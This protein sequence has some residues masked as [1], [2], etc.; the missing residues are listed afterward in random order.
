MSGQNT[1]LFITLLLFATST[2]LLKQNHEF[3]E[4][5]GKKVAPLHTAFLYFF[6]LLVQARQVKLS[7]LNLQGL[8]KRRKQILLF[9]R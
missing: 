8:I 2:F 1:Y 7:A 9:H 6:F 5:F 4:Y 3:L